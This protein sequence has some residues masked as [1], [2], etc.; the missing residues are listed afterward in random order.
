MLEAVETLWSSQ[1]KLNKEINPDLIL[2]FGTEH[3]G[4]EEYVKTYNMLQ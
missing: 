4:R 3:V 1:K 2:G